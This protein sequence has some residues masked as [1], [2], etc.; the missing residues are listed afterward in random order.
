M[1][2]QGGGRSTATLLDLAVVA[3]GITVVCSAGR[4]HKASSIRWPRGARDGTVGRARDGKADEG[5][6][7]GSSH[8][9]ST[10]RADGFAG[11]A[12]GARIGR[13]D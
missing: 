5:S 13:R 2:S 7:P 11:G 4:K 10:G 6:T 8:G 12:G 1:V 9:P 3:A